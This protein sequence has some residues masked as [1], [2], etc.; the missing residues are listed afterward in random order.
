MAKKNQQ[1]ATTKQ[2]VEIRDI[3]DDVI[4]LKTGRL[5]PCLKLA[6]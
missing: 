4:I 3:K 1:A 2:F 5:G 6:L